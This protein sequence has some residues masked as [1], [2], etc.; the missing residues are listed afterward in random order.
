VNFLNVGP[1]ELTLI[2][3]IAILLVGPRRMVEIARTIGRVSSQLRQ[4]SNEVTSTL[5]AEILATERE[6]GRETGPAPEKIV[7]DM[8]APIT[9]IQAKLQ[10]TEHETRQALENIVED[11]TAPTASIQAELQAT[12]R[13]TRRALGNITKN[14]PGQETR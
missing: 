6:T 9:S 13:E 8:I 14:N 12:E 7:E 3:I 4:L 1:W 11:I 5:Q 2:L 10:T